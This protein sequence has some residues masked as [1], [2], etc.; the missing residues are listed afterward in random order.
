MEDWY[1]QISWLKVGT[2]MVVY[3]DLDTQINPRQISKVGLTRLGPI[4]RFAEG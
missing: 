3:R 2:N 4:K 1:K